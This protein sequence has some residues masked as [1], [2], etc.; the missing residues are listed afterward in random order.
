MAAT[1]ASHAGMLHMLAFLAAMPGTGDVTPDDPPGFLTAGSSCQGR[2]DTVITSPTEAKTTGSESSSNREPSGHQNAACRAEVA[3]ALAG[4]VGGARW[5]WERSGSFYEKPSDRH[6][7]GRLDFGSTTRTHAWARFKH[8]HLSRR[9]F[10]RGKKWRSASPTSP[11]VEC[12]GLLGESLQAHLVSRLLM[13]LQ[14]LCSSSTGASSSQ[15]GGQSTSAAAA[16]AGPGPKSQILGLPLVI[17]QVLPHF[18]RVAGSGCSPM[19]QERT[20]GWG[21]LPTGP[22][23]L[24]PSV[25]ANMSGTRIYS[26]SRFVSPKSLAPFY[27][28]PYLPRLRW[29]HRA[30]HTCPAQGWAAVA[31]ASAAVDVVAKTLTSSRTV[32]VSSS[33]EKDLTIEG[34]KMDP[35]CSSAC[36]CAWLKAWSSRQKTSDSKEGFR[37]F[38]LRS[39]NLFSPKP[40]TLNPTSET[41]KPYVHPPP[42]P[43]IR[44]PLCSGS[45][46]RLLQ[47]RVSAPWLPKSF[48]TSRAQSPVT[49]DNYVQGAY[50]YT[51]FPPGHAT[52]TTATAASAG[53]AKT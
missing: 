6:L 40:Y 45:L 21:A 48:Q 10:P 35:Q 25:P 30:T 37:F 29:L 22:L 2:D 32:Y 33:Q 36:M 9:R 31:A 27:A 42:S 18:R 39:I 19:G 41:P 52:R 3:S 47:E 7:Q 4:T 49:D 46:G 20:E 44:N 34:G 50:A 24:A 16:A 12:A 8:R 17:R 53:P 43:Q 14:V 15:G 5:S 23:K 26:I 13:F 1:R 51:H 28:H 38:G 11:K